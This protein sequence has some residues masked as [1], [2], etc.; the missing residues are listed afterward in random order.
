MNKNNKN[1]TS[2]SDLAK[3]WNCQPYVKKIR[4]AQKLKAVRNKF[5]EKHIC[6]G[7]GYPMVWKEGT[8]IA[9]CSNSDCK[10][11]PHKKKDGEITYYPSFEILD[12]KGFS[13]ASSIKADYIEDNELKNF[14]NKKEKKG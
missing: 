3:D 1:Y 13:I 4:N 7:C 14:L 6:K 12:E 8:Y 2:F 9:V 5:F 10:G 11:V